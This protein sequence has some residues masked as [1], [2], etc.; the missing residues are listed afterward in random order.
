MFDEGFL[1]SNYKVSRLD[2]LELV[3]GL[4]CTLSLDCYEPTSFFSSHV[5]AYKYPSGKCLDE[6]PNCIIVQR[7]CADLIVNALSV[8]PVYNV[9]NNSEC[10]CECC[11]EVECAKRQMLV[12]G[13]REISGL[14]RRYYI[15]DITEL[16]IK[17]L[18]YELYCNYSFRS[19]ADL[20]EVMS[21]GVKS[22]INLI[23]AELDRSTV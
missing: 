8:L 11:D 18:F 4:E 14:T 3:K 22:A 23:K 13:S 7:D 10:E 2:L 19:N 21:V 17:A 16:R 9:S 1:H 5:M 12:N 20:K 15:R 6:F